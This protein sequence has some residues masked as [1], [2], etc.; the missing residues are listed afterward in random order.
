MA[1]IRSLLQDKVAKLVCKSFT[2]EEVRDVSPHFRRL[3]ISSD[4]L[5]TSSSVSAGDKVQ[6]MVPESG[7]RTYSPFAH[8]VTRSSVDLLAYVHDDGA[9]ARWLRAAARGGELLIFGPRGSLALGTLAGPVVLFGDETSY[10]A[11][12]ALRGARTAGDSLAFVFE[13]SDPDESATALRDVGIEPH[14]LV[15]RE[16]GALHL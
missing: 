5:R 1:S 10:G 3:R 12:A 11:A 16:P 4:A 14:A 7:P 13:C 2:F 15:R 9:T 6:I 8:D